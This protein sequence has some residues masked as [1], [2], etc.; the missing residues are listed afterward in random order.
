LSASGHGLG[1]SACG[2]APELGVEDQL[3]GIGSEV[4]NIGA[5]CAA[6]VSALSSPP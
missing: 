1:V 2:V 6:G 5:S 4:K 3:R